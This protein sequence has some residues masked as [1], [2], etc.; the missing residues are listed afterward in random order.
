MMDRRIINT[1]RSDN[2]ERR[3][4][5]RNTNVPTA[6]QLAVTAPVVQER[7]VEIRSLFRASGPI[8]VSFKFQIILFLTFLRLL[9][10]IC[11]L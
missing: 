10:S 6:L 2:E 3:L 4:L 7:S 1:T 11:D 9:R 5:A 8:I